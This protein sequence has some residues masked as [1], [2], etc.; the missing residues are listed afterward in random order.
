MIPSR[1]LVEHVTDERQQHV[2]TIAHAARRARQVDDERTVLG[3]A[4]EPTRED[5]RRDGRRALAPEQLGDPGQMP[6]DHRERPLGRLVA[7]ADAGPAGGDDEP[8]TRSKSRSQRLL[9][10]LRP[11]GHDHHVGHGEARRRQPLDGHGTRAVLALAGRGPVGHDDDRSQERWGRLHPANVRTGDRP[12]KSGAPREH[13]RPGRPK[14]HS[15]VRWTGRT[16]GS[17][18]ARGRYGPTGV[19]PVP[20]A[21]NRGVTAR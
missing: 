3:H 12:R 2:E 10:R 18:C 14:A 20:R 16:T 17:A 11:V 9:H 7:R 19:T 1:H 13:S 6:V 21:M 8:G 4:R 15:T 5:S